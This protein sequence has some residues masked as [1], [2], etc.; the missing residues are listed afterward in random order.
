[1]RNMNDLLE[2]LDKL[3][4]EYKFREIPDSYPHDI[5]GCIGWFADSSNG[6]AGVIQSQFGPETAF[7]CPKAPATQLQC[8]LHPLI[9][10]AAAGQ[11]Q[12]RC[13]RQ[14]HSFHTPSALF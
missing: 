2:D 1:M 6:K 9:I 13:Q 11:E 8:L 7:R 12:D 5:V 3:V 10:G 4:H 14:R